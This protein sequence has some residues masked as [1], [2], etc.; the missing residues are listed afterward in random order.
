M[1]FA[2]FFILIDGS[3]LSNCNIFVKA[4][5]CDIKKLIFVEAVYENFK[6]CSSDAHS[7][8]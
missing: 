6:R 7:L 3:L 8:V 4:L 1:H 5:T 2:R